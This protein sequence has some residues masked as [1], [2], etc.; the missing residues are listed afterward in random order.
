MFFVKYSYRVGY[1]E[2]Q[3]WRLIWV[4][5]LILTLLTLK[6]GTVFRGVPCMEVTSM[7]VHPCQPTPNPVH[8]GRSTKISGT[9]LLCDK[10]LEPPFT[11]QHGG[12]DAQYREGHTYIQ[13]QH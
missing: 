12:R 5:L 11:G 4:T 2:L 10:P 13:H 6:M 7:T 9:V 1:I 8:A 3:S